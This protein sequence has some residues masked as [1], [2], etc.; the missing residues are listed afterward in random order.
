MLRR[1]SRGQLQHG[2]LGAP[3]PTISSYLLMA[4]NKSLHLLV[5]ELPRGRAGWLVHWETRV[6][7]RELWLLIPTMFS[8]SVLGFPIPFLFSLFGWWSKYYLRA[9]SPLDCTSTKGYLYLITGAILPVAR[10]VCLAYRT[11]YMFFCINKTLPYF[12]QT[13]NSRTLKNSEVLFSVTV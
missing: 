3:K 6:F 12:W 7:R 9:T 2:A 5:P 1:H 4:T 8:T 13:G 11:V 10:T